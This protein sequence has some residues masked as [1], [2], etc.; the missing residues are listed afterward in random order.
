MNA[1]SQ[2][3]VGIDTACTCGDTGDNVIKIAGAKER[4]G[5]DSS[6]VSEY[7]CSRGT[8]SQGL[9]RKKKSCSGE[10]CGGQRKSVDGKKYGRN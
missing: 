9:L 7:R 6:R 2:G 4:T 8:D 5:D 3:F 1:P 10:S